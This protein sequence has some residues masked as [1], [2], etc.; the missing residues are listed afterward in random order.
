MVASVICIEN[1]EA[2]RGAAHLR[3][4]VASGYQEEP[5]Y[6]VGYRIG[7]FPPAVLRELFGTFFYLFSL[8][9]IFLGGGFNAPES[10]FDEQ[11]EELPAGAAV[12][13]AAVLESGGQYA[14]LP[15]GGEREGGGV[16][17][18]GKPRERAR[19]R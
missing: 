15:E 3:T 9:P 16:I 5:Y 8:A 12:S 17:L 7:L 10:T 14:P 19:H 6:S 11:Q 18:P 4:S 13:R 1:R 2:H